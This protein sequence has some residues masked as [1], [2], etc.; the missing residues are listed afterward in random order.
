MSASNVTIVPSYERVKN[1]VSV[2][3][4][5]NTKEI[6]IEVNDATA[7]VYEDKVVFKVIPEDGYEIENIEIRDENNNTVEY[8]KTNNNNEYVFTM[9]DTDVT[10]KPIYRKIESINVPDTIKNPNTGTG[11]CIIMSI[12]ALIVSTSF[13]LIIKKDYF[14]K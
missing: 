2:E 3:E 11:T 6:I 14:L 10:I 12:I 8:K 7:V 1:A 13:Y 5:N 9:P 4:N